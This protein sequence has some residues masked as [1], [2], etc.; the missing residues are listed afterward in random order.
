MPGFLLDP[1][2]SIQVDVVC[3]TDNILV[4][5]PGVVELYGPQKGGRPEDIPVMTMAMREFVNA[6]NRSP[7]LH[8]I[9]GSMPGSGA[10][11]GIGAAL[12]ALGSRIVSREDAMCRYFNIHDTMTL[13]PWDL[14]ITA[15]GSLDAQSTRGKALGALMRLAEQRNIPVIAIAGTVDAA[16]VDPSGLWSATSVVPGPMDLALAVEF[17]EILVTEQ[18]KQIIRLIRLGR[19]LGCQVPQVL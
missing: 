7:T 4:G 18:S 10:S 12:L 11:G 9:H 6:V 17:T 15:E 2:H 5:P 14:I 3:N 13:M 1:N 19:H 8:N 16:C